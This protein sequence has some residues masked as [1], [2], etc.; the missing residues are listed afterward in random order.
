M[1][2]GCGSIGLALSVAVIVGWMVVAKT[3]THAYRLTIEVATPEGPRSAS[4]V[5]HVFAPC[6]GLLHKLLPIG[7]G[8]GSRVD[9]EAAFLDL[10]GG[11]NL[12]ALM[13]AGPLGDNVDQPIGLAYYAMQDAG[14]INT[15][16]RAMAPRLRLCDFTLQTGTTVLSPRLLPTLVTF[17]DLTN[18]ASARVVQPTEAGFASVLGPGY[19]L[20]RV[21][22]EMVPVGIWPLNLIGLWGE[23]VTR[24]I[25]QDMPVIITKLAAQAKIPGQVEYHNQPHRPHLGQFRN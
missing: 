1:K 9:G 11:R 18:P 24:D 2:W 4:V 14:L 6:T 22:V 17:T 8:A 5:R 3:P 12:I 16:R 23:R 7:A 25:E 10:G 19:R 13:A 21:A 20:A 15:D